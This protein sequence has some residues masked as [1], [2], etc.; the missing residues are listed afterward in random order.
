[1]AELL[2]L[3]GPAGHS[4]CVSDGLAAAI[5]IVLVLLAGISRRLGVAGRSQVGISRLILR[6]VG[7]RRLSLCA[8]VLRVAFLTSRN[9]NY[10]CGKRKC[11]DDNRG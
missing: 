6:L 5:G 2:K 11:L 8:A 10:Q 4:P 3:E 7:L 1:V 9:A